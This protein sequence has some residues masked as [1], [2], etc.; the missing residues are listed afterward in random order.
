MSPASELPTLPVSNPTRSFW[1]IT[2]PNPLVR[3][4][5]TPE[6]PQRGD[7]VII[8]SGI[9]GAFVA[10]ELI[11]SGVT[12]VVVVEARD[13][14]SGATGRVSLCYIISWAKNVSAAYTRQCTFHCFHGL[15]KPRTLPCSIS[16]SLTFPSFLP[17]WRPLPA[18]AL[19]STPHL[20]QLRTREFSLPLESHRPF[21]YSLRLF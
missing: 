14:C 18:H 17:E 6:L 12:N 7:V 11:A 21:Q 20:G 8:G 1:H 2:H 9:T 5:T 10:R 13:I 4:R 19:L 3:H 15:D 16:H